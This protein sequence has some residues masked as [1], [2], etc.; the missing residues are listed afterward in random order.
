[1]ELR[2]TNAERTV[3]QSIV[4]TAVDARQAMRALAL[5]A[6]ADG[7]RPVAV[8]RRLQV[9][10]ATIYE[11][12]KRWRQRPQSP[13]E[14]LADRPRSG[15]PPTVHS[16]LSEQLPSLMDTKPAAFGYRQSEWTV[17]L[18]RAHLADRNL[19]ASD[20]SVRRELRAMGYRWKRPRLALRRRSATWRQAKGG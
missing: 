8:A 1:M 18:L 4:A 17:E 3:L 19:R 14:R 11:W 6:L 16:A 20:G 9:T 15:R 12:V 10:R 5:L 2:L 13:A 7:E